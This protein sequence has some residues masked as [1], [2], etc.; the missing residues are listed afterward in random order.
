M[1]LHNITLSIEFVLYTLFVLV[2]PPRLT[3]LDRTDPTFNLCRS[4]LSLPVLYEPKWR[5]KSMKR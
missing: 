1:H 4:P 5:D 3:G 2:R